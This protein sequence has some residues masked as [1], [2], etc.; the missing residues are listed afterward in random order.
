MP[1]AA[2]IG[3]V[4]SL[5]RADNHIHTSAGLAGSPAACLLRKSYWGWCDSDFGVVRAHA[6]QFQQI[7]WRENYHMVVTKM[8]ISANVYLQHPLR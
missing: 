2:A 3:R 5:A 6:V 8:E 1:S 7:L 4:V